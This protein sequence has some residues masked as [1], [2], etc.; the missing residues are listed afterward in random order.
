MLVFA[1]FLNK[2]V[3]VDWRRS[4]NIYQIMLD[5]YRYIRSWFVY[6]GA[7]LC[8]VMIA[9]PVAVEPSSVLVCLSGSMTWLVTDGPAG[10]WNFMGSCCQSASELGPLGLL[11]SCFSSCSGACIGTWDFCSG[12]LSSLSDGPSGLLEYCS[13]SCAALWEGASSGASVCGSMGSAVYS[14]GEYMY[15]SCAWCGSRSMSCLNEYGPVLIG[16]LTAIRDFIWSVLM[17]IWRQVRLF[18]T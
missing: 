18:F 2:N 13:G 3:W 7:C 15:S 10:A 16:Y 17:W 11:E 1:I 12:C 8:G 14:V 5:I 4:R 6:F 9:D